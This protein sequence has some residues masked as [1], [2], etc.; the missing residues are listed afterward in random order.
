VSVIEEPLLFIEANGKLRNGIFLRG[1]ALYADRVA[2]DVFASRAF[3]A[4]D[5]ADIRLTDDLDTTYKMVPLAAEALDG[6][7]RIEFLPAVP[8]E[9][10]QLRLGE[11]GWSLIIFHQPD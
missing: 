11:P 5:L 6:R 8:L 10:S 4:D 7:G 1:V 3:D 2:F 9:W